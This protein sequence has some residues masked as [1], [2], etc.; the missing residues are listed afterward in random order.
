M[1]LIL[2]FTKRT[3]YTLVQYLLSSENEEVII[4]DLKH[5]QEQEELLESLSTLG[6]KRVYNELGNQDSSLLEKYNITKIFISPGVPRSIQLVQVALSLGIEVLNDI[7]YFYRLFPNRIYVAITGTDGKTTVAQWLENIVLQ[8]KKVVLVGNIGVPIFK[9]AYKKYDDYIFIIELSSFQLESMSTFRAFIALITNIHEDHLDRYEGMLDYA[10]TKKKI[11]F[12]QLSTD[13]ALINKDNEYIHA[14]GKEL[15]SCTVSF[16]LNDSAHW[17]Y[18][19]GTIYF[20]EHIF[21]D[22]N[23]L[24]VVGMHNIQNAMMVAALA[25]ILG[26]DVQ[27]I[28]EGLQAFMGIPHRLQFVTQYKGTYFYNDSKATTLQAVRFALESFDKPVVLLVGGRSKDIDFS[29][30]SKLV[31]QKTKKVYFFGEMGQKLSEIWNIPCGTLCETMKDAVIQA[32]DFA[33]E[34]IILL[35]PGGTSFDEYASYIDRGEH[36]ISLIDQHIKNK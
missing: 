8:Q 29:P 31:L 36:F 27:I 9:F 17:F 4:A 1:Y 6:N 26:I 25:V 33:K 13:I 5:T 23:L 30:L 15:R 28:R 20:D 32:I 19:D 24:K 35:S 34:D 12:N 2:G 3:S 21:F 10:L 22:T 11:F 18:K 16:S 14:F 7:E